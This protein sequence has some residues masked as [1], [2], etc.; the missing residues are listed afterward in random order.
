M[1]AARK[2]S[3]PVRE[4]E[5]QELS[6]RVIEVLPEFF[7]TRE[8]TDAGWVLDYSKGYAKGDPIPPGLVYELPDGRLVMVDGFHRHAA[9]VKLGLKTMRCQ[10]R[11]GTE[12]E[13]IL[14][15]IE[16]NR[17]KYHKGRP[18]T[19]GDATAAAEK[20][21]L[22]G[23]G[24]PGEGS[25]DWSDTEIGRVAGLSRETVRYARM[26]FLESRGIPLPDRVR[27]FE[28]GIPGVRHHP[29]KRPPNTAGVARVTE[30]SDGTFGIR[31]DGKHSRLGSSRR[32]ADSFRSRIIAER[33]PA[34]ASLGDSAHFREW[35][36]ARRVAASGV[37]PGEFALGGL[38][39]RDSYVYPLPADD[40]GAMLAGVGRCCLAA[41]QLGWV[42]RTILCCY[43][44]GPG[45]V[46]RCRSLAASLTPPVEFLT[47]DELIAEFGGTPDAA[48]EGVAE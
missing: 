7:Q 31:V 4:F 38:R 36:G 11:K 34:L 48:G 1:S 24:R 29:Y 47:P 30:L 3:I 16:A 40:L 39:V 17:A 33:Q 26:R 28:N 27:V 12:T 42:Q 15:G 21:I 9:R 22:N 25:W 2:P 35:L 46:A 44:P 23:V 10:V 13:A 8:N 45:V 32:E 19:E 14:A 20:L 37:L 6:M 43:H 18:Y 41:S 5:E